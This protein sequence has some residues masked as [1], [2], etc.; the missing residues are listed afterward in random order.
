MDDRFHDRLRSI[1][2]KLQQ[3]LRRDQTAIRHGITQSARGDLKTVQQIVQL[4]DDPYNRGMT[5]VHKLARQ[6]ASAF[7]KDD[8]QYRMMMLEDIM[9][10]VSNVHED[11]VISAAKQLGKTSWR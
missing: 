6:L 8:P 1:S 4:S 9:Q 5:R 3:L 2:E 10:A 7:N 11:D